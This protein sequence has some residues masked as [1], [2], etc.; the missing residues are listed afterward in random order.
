[1]F[2]VGRRSWL[3]DTFLSKSCQISLSR[4]FIDTESPVQKSSLEAHSTWV[5]CASRL[6]FCDVLIQLYQVTVGLIHSPAEKAQVWNH[7][8]NVDCTLLDCTDL[9]KGWCKEF[10]FLYWRCSSGDICTTIKSVDFQCVDLGCKRTKE[11]CNIRVYWNRSCGSTFHTAYINFSS[12][13]L[14]SVLTLFSRS[15]TS[16]S[17]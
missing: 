14:I 6:D 16:F 1:M 2:D 9:S 7:N 17:F 5:E 8:Q 12:F 3:T 13:Y 4:R 10:K 15:F 11:N